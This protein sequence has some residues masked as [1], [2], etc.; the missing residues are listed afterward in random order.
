MTRLRSGAGP[1]TAGLGVSAAAARTSPSRPSTPRSG[2]PVSFLAL[3]Y[4]ECKER[5]P[6]SRR[7]QPFD[8][9]VG[10]PLGPRLVVAL[11]GLAA[12]QDCLDLGNVD[13]GAYRPSALCGHQ[14]LAEQAAEGSVGVGRQ[15]VDVDAQST[16]SL[17]QAL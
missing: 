12:D 3:A 15:G 6:L 2:V 13:V 11:H 1:P 7:A 14:Q 9:D 5:A 17:D 4:I 8:D 16:E 10:H